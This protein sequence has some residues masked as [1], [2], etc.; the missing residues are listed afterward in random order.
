MADYKCP[1]VYGGARQCTPNN[2]QL[3]LPTT[4]LVVV[5]IENNVCGQALKVT[6]VDVANISGLS[7]LGAKDSRSPKSVRLLFLF[8][9]SD[10][11]PNRV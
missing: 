8:G 10:A 2:K 3:Y 9:A 5:V 11:Y 1:H 4:I 7:L 6:E